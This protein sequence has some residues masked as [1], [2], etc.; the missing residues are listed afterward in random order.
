MLQD[1][2]PYFR[3][4]NATATFAYRLKMPGWRLREKQC[5]FDAN[6]TEARDA[7]E[8]RHTCRQ[9]CLATETVTTPRD[10][11]LIAKIV[12]VYPVLLQQFVHSL[13][14][15]ARLLGCLRHVAMMVAE[16]RSEVNLLGL[17]HGFIAR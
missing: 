5:T 12:G 10:S 7:S 8:N 14:R 11:C 1:D 16:Q 17:V 3:E 15:H 4:A 9:G 2:M 6:R 13:P